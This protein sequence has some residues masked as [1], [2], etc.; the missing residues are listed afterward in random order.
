MRTLGVCLGA[1]SV[2]MVWLEQNG[3]QITTLREIA[4]AHDGNPRA[5][6]ENLLNAKHPGYER[7][8][9]TGKKLRH[10]VNATA[11]SEPEAVEIAVLKYFQL[12]GRNI[13]RLISAGGETFSVYYLNPNGRIVSVHTG[14]K[15]A[16]GTGE[17]FLQQIKRMDL[18]IE[19]ALNEAEHSDPYHVAGRCSVFCK[20]DCTHALNKGV[21]KDK[22]VAGL[23]EMMAGKVIELLEGDF[24]SPVM[25]I[26]GSSQNTAMIRFLNERL[27]S[28]TIPEHAPYFEAYGAA[29]YCLNNKTLPLANPLFKPGHSSFSFLKPLSEYADKVSY[30][31]TQHKKAV[32]GDVLILGLDVGSTTTKAVLIRESDNAI[33]ADIYLRTNGD[34]ITASR[35]CFASLIR[36]VPEDVK[37]IGLGVTGSGRQIVGLFSLTPSV[38]NEI[39]AHA[40]AAAYYDSAVDTIFEIGGQDAKYTYLTRGVASDYAMNEAC[41]AGTGSFLE[42]AA[43]ESLNIKTEEI[44]DLAMSAKRPPNFSDQCA[45]FINSDIKSAIQEGISIPD[46]AAGLVYS[47]CLNYNNRVKSSRPVGHKIFMQGGVC[48]NKAVP[49]AMAAL[50]G[51]DI[52]VPPDPGLMGAFGVALA[53]KQQINEGRLEKASYNLSELARREVKYH[54]P[55]ICAG[56]KEKC[57][58]K[59]SINRI[60][61][62]GRIYPFGGACNKY[63]NIVHHHNAPDVASLDM[64]NL[65][66]EWVFES[67]KKNRGKNSKTIGVSRSLLTN[68]LF[69][70]YHAFFHSLGY[71]VVLS[72]ESTRRGM[73]RRK[74]DFCYPMELSHGYLDSLILEK[75]DVLF[76]PHVKSLPD[77]NGDRTS[78]TCPFVQSEPYTLLAAFPEAEKIQTF[79]PV[80]DFKDG[81][82]KASAE[83]FNIG[84]KLGHKTADIKK[85]WNTALKKQEQFH[86]RCK[87]KGKEFLKNLEKQDGF[88]VVIVGRPYNAWTSEANMGI[89]HKFASRGIPVI[90]LDFLPFE[91]E[92]PNEQMYWAMGQ[93]ILKAAKLV[94]R[95][96]K[97]YAAYISNFSC[98]PDSFIITRFRDIMGRKPSLTLEL[99]SHSADAGIDT[100]VEAFLDVIKSTRNL[101]LSFGQ[102]NDFKPATTR[103]QGKEMQI[104]DSDG[105]IH[106]LT[107]PEV[108]LLIPSMGDI[109]SRGLAAAYRSAGIRAEAVPAPGE[110]ELRL[111]RANTTGKECLPLQITVGSLLADIEKGRRPG[112]IL[113]YFMPETSGPCRFGQY[114]M[115]IKRLIEKHKLKNIA[116][117]SLTAENSYAGLSTSVVLKAWK[118]VVLSDVLDDIHASLLTTAKDKQKAARIFNEVTEEILSSLEKDNGSVLYKKIAAGME[119]ITNI[120]LKQKPE[121]CPVVG[122]TGEIYVRRDPLAS[123]G[124]V[125]K[126]SAKGIIVRPSPVSEWLYYTDYI[127]E[128]DL[129]VHSKFLQRKVTALKRLVKIFIEKKLKSVLSKSGHTPAHPVKVKPFIDN[130]SGLISPRLTGEAILT[131]GST[132]TEIADDLDGVIAI[133]PFGCM[134]GRIAESII[135]SKLDDIKPQA[136]KHVDTLNKLSEEFPNLPFLPVE[137]DGNV[138]TQSIETRLETFYLQVRRMHEKRK[139]LLKSNDKRFRT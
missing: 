5:T 82:D 120:P 67:M 133:A 2:S 81:Y 48:Y 16:S 57:D 3:D 80:L 9:V 24:D 23:S 131:I 113:V 70:L 117:L 115:L 1:S 93:Q 76:L 100:R 96:P 51:R 84:K 108:R 109:G 132:I 27:K 114:N 78:V 130:V 35:A 94:A 41:S 42:E 122:L 68:T 56:G 59:C 112:E 64:V 110:H 28:L 106:H 17:F 123:Q 102:E 45:A 99:D 86:R 119:R 7:I 37:I 29:L 62:N 136:T 124:L 60:E 44:G 127:V 36:Q 47:I 8:A 34:P 118:A 53:V 30:K 139:E 55:F 13:S 4:V 138:L 21:A 111:G 6:L 12:H 22:V 121:D 46:I 125:E 69:P 129:V 40:T 91:E 31:S 72:K 10:A 137:V 25:I 19:E 85:A 38:I 26:G 74:A 95:H 32:S 103:M 135:S 98:G 77:T 83:F 39:I 54:E 104:I 92:S 52:I 43:G 58:R 11:I 20:S 101:S 75:P 18:S 116:I 61:I 73:E 128:H 66:E 87:E 88:A 79:T 33:C 15:C 89:P 90:P 65:R 49:V 63:E 126:L 50:T 134:P 14:N 97:L 105:R 107:D 71:T